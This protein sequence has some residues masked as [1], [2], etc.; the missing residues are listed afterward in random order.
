MCLPSDPSPAFA[1][2]S[3]A[4]DLHW[5]KNATIGQKIHD[6]VVGNDEFDDEDTREIALVEK[7]DCYLRHD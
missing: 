6:V 2:L 3:D 4:H 1:L 5:H 7:L